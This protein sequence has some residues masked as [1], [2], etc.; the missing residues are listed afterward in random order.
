[1]PHVIRALVLL[2]L[3]PAVV[4]AC[5]APAP[6]RSPGAEPTAIGTTTSAPLASS[7]ES[8]AASSAEAGAATGEIS[9]PPTAPACRVTATE[10]LG[11]SASEAEALVAPARPRLESCHQ[12]QGTD[13]K[14][15]IRVHESDGKLAFEVQPDSSLDP[16][17]KQCVLDALSKLN[18]PTLT[19]LSYGPSVPP[20][21]FTSLITIEW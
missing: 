7:A 17:E 8:S 20:T 11:C 2:P 16:T 4:F 21:G 14:L 19:N 18:D 15:R 12:G 13:G 1:M 3:L 5:G 10:T 9:G 6:A